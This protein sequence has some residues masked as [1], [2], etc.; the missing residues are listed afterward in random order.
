MYPG[1]AATASFILRKTDPAYGSIFTIGLAYGMGVALGI[2][3]CA[4]TSGGHFN[5][6]ITICYAI[7]Q[8]FPWRKVPYFIFAQ[9]AGAFFAALILYGQYHEQIEVYRL[10][11]EKLGMPD[12]FMGGPASI[13]TSY[14]QGLQQH[15]G[16]LV[17]IEFFVDAFIVRGHSAIFFILIEPYVSTTYSTRVSPSGPSSTHPIP[18]SLPALPPSSSVSP[19]V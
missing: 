16:W 8:D 4:G 1:I 11:L 18:S 7:W 5:P 14:P 13:F 10:G 17:L 15:Q 9:V 19:T 3:C 2:I 12:V 6:S